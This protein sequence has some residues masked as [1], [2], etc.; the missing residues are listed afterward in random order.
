[1]SYRHPLLLSIALALALTS[2]CEPAATP[3]RDIDVAP[4]SGSGSAVKAEDAGTKKTKDSTYAGDQALPPEVLNGAYLR[5]D[6]VDIDEA[7]SDDLLKPG[8]ADELDTKK[9]RL[10]SCALHKNASDAKARKKLVDIS[11]LQK[12]WVVRKA[13]A[14]K[15][16]DLIIT[17][18]IIQPGKGRTAIFAVP[19]DLVN[20]ELEMD[21]EL[22]GKDPD[23]GKVRTVIVSGRLAA[24]D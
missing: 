19:K 4:S 12:R 3:R 24:G 14:A 10:V 13:G 18:N 23:S 9:E 20:E 5:L 15:S 6:A 2:A 16:K 8:A 11:K 7:E 22:T 21:L 17:K 1:M